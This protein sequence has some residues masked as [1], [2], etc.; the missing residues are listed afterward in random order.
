MAVSGF[1]RV[2]KRTSFPRRFIRGML[3][4]VLR[5]FFSEGPILGC[6]SGAPVFG[7]RGTEALSV[8]GPSGTRVRTLPVVLQERAC[9]RSWSLG[10]R[11]SS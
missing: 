9:A 5:E 6:F 10:V 2:L 1:W 11:F 8:P 7:C 4:Q 3:D